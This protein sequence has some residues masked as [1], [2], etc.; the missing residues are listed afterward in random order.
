MTELIT[1]WYVQYTK[2]Y[3]IKCLNILQ[4]CLK[5]KSELLQEIRK[6]LPS[7]N[8]VYIILLLL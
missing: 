5:V 1:E 4:I 8:K 6:N 3:I 2:P 7:V